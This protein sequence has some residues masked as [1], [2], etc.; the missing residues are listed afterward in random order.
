MDILVTCK[1]YGPG[2]AFHSHAEKNSHNYIVY[3]S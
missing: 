3:S 2:D 1:T